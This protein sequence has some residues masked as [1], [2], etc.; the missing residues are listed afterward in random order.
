MLD[1]VLGYLILLPL[2]LVSCTFIYQTAVSYLESRAIERLGSFA[3]RVRNSLPFGIDIIF[4]S[5]S[6]SRKDTLLELW[7]WIF[8]FTP[9][10]LCCTAEFYIANQRVIFT[11]DPE[12]I[13]AVLAVS[14]SNHFLQDW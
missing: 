3:P 11:A 7:D 6:H 4:R 9:T 13:K 5:I 1:H 12:N 8:T 2:L 10:T 14:V